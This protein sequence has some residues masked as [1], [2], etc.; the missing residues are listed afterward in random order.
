MEQDRNPWPWCNYDAPGIGAFRDC[1]PG[2]PIPNPLWQAGRCVSTNGGGV[3][4]VKFVIYP[5]CPNAGAMATSSAAARGPKGNVVG[6]S[7]AAPAVVGGGGG[8]PVAPAVVGGGGGRGPVA[9]AVIEGGG[10][11]PLQPSPALVQQKPAARA[12]VAVQQK[13]AAPA[14]EAVVARPPQELELR[15]QEAQLDLQEAQL[16]KSTTSF[17]EDIRG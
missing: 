12:V 3:E 13:P 1:N 6:G 10:N 7:P 5:G 11:P 4:D 9:P 15:K 8:G 16:D 17:L 14:L 2:G